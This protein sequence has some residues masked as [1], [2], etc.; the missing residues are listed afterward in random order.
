MICHICENQIQQEITGEPYMNFKGIRFCFDCYKGLIPK[1]Y[2]MA[3]FGDGGII[4]FLFK[5]CLSSSHNKKVRRTIKNYKEILKQLLVKYK[6]KCVKCQS[7]ENIT[8]DH[9]T[10]VSKGGSDDP[11]NLQILCKPCN[12]KKGTKIENE[13]VSSVPILS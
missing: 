9:I 5:E 13:K 11:S 1:I 12:S 10:P 7:K 4:H 6:F 2:S 3:G 8:I